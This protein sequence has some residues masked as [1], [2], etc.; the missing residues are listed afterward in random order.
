MTTA[1][2]NEF[3]PWEATE[4]GQRPPLTFGETLHTFRKCEA[5]TLKQAGEKLG[6]SPQL[7]NAYEKGRKLPSP[8]L[9]AK[10]ADA[11]GMDTLYMVQLALQAQ[12]KEAG[13]PYSV[14]LAS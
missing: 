8:K 11:F 2:D 12:L 14:Q 3:I 5:W 6:I 4:L 9:A 1:Q 10:M 7:V 13:L